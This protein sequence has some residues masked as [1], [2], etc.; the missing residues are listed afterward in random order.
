MNRY[1]RHE[2]GMVLVTTMVM[3]MMMA[4]LVLSL[5]QAVFLYGKSSHH[6]T[7]GHQIIQEM[8]AIGNRPDFQ[9]ALACQTGRYQCS[10]TDAGVFPCLLIMQDGELYGSRHWQV[11]IRDPESNRFL[12]IRFARPEK[13]LACKEDI[14]IRIS[15]GVIGYRYGFS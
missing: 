12:Q 6:L 4:W 11:M 5:L 2:Q 13:A 8:E 1:D 3:V 15:A 7:D 10:M 14:T 9:H